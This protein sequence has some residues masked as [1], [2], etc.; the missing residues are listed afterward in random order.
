VPAVSVFSGRLGA[1]DKWLER[2]R[3]VHVL[4]GV[5]DVADVQVR[6]AASR[7]LPPINSEA[8]RQIIEGICAP[9]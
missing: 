3:R 5:A 7:Q 9:I 8:L 1:V 2:Q 4:H 6:R